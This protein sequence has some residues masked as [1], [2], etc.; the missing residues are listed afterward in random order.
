MQDAGGSVAKYDPMHGGSVRPLTTDPR[1]PQ[2]CPLDRHTFESSTVAWF[3]RDMRTSPDVRLVEVDSQQV[4]V[5]DW[6]QRSL[7][8]RFL[9]GRFLL[10]REHRFL[11]LLAGLEGV[12]RSLGFPDADSL[13]IE[14]LSGRTL[15]D[16]N[17]DFLPDF[18]DRLDALVRQ[19]HERGIAH[20]DLDQE[21][22]IVVQEDGH[23]AIIDFGGSI[24]RSVLPLRRH[25]FDLLSRHDLRC[26]ERQRRRF[27][28]PPAPPG[29]PPVPH[30]APW[31]KRL[32]VFF[33]KMD[34][35]D[36]P[37]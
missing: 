28:Q 19:I 21:N 31:Q 6:G 8:R 34:R 10:R 36:A 29:A 15:S 27:D 20:G 16:V 2:I 1:D 11:T 25:Y 4:V 14:Y 17:P 7:A 24:Q 33:R 18:F 26:V 5:K 30:L 12:P 37:P 35:E 9:L 23:P 22:N 32:L 3:R 13:A